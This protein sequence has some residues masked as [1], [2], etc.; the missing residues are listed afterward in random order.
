MSS[1]KRKCVKYFL[2]QFP[3]LFCE[4]MVIVVFG[5]HFCNQTI[6]RDSVY[7]KAVAPKDQIGGELPYVTDPKHRWSQL[8]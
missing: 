4:V 3:D 5:R 1:R 7:I 8:F 2:A 6:H